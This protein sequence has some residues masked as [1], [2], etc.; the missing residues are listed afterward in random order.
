MD[1]I[2]K[3]RIEHVNKSRNLETPRETFWIPFIDSFKKTNFKPSIDQLENSLCK[4]FGKNISEKLINYC[5]RSINFN[6]RENIHNVN[7]KIF[8]QAILKAIYSGQIIIKV[9]KLDYNSLDI[10]LLIE[11]IEKLFDIFDDNFDLMRLF[12]DSYVPV[13]F[14]ESLKSFDGSSYGI[15]YSDV[16]LS[17]DFNFPK[18]EK[19]EQNF[20]HSSDNLITN[21]RQNNS[22]D[23]T[24]WLV[25]LFTSP[26]LL[27]FI[28]AFIIFFLAYQEEIKMKKVYLDKNE[29]LNAQKEEVI[30][31]YKELIKEYKEQKLDSVDLQSMF[32]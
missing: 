4:N 11:P 31:D 9:E 16:N 25:G 1:N 24:K 30:K 12:F 22:I 8:D 23:K 7:N 14:F 28:L 6:Y 17:Y 26:L 10:D 32:Q 29:K 27:P 5:S 20:T 19:N 21:E 15:Y 18:R 3:V 13:A 2:I